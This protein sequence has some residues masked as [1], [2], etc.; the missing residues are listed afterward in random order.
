MVATSYRAAGSAKVG[1]KVLISGDYIS[2]MQLPS[3]LSNAGSS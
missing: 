2:E 1:M 3:S